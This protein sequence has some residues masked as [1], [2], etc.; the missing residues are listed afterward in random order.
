MNS[1]NRFKKTAVLLL[2]ATL[3]CT[4]LAIFLPYALEPLLGIAAIC[5]AIHTV[6]NLCP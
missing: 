1:E 5:I 2:A 4:V 6:C 3:I